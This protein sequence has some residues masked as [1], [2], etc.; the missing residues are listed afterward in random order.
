MCPLAFAQV[1]QCFDD[2]A[3]D[4]TRGRLFDGGPDTG[5]GEQQ[6]SHY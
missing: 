4:G 3:A 2:G 5:L 6:N 1:R